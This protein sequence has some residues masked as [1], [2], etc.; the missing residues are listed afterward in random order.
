MKQENVIHNKNRS[1]KGNKPQDNQ[2][3]DKGIKTIIN[4]L[5]S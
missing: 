2:M 1:V 5:R 3:V 4:S